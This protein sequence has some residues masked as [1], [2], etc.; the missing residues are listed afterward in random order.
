MILV[1]H[2]ST[3]LGESSISLSVTPSNPVALFALS[4]LI[5]L[6]ISSLGAAGKSKLRNSG[7]RF[8]FMVAT[9]DDFC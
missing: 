9:L 4:N 3:I 5:I 2:L 6:F 8:S 7:K 1:R